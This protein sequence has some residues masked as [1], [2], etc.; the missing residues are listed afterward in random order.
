MTPK[1]SPTCEDVLKENCTKLK[2]IYGTGIKG[3]HSCAGNNQSAIRKAECTAKK[4]NDWCN[5]NF[6]P[7]DGDKPVSDPLAGNW[8]PSPKTKINYPY[9]LQIEMGD[10]NN[11]LTYIQPNDTKVYM[12]KDRY[13]TYDIGNGDHYQISGTLAK[14]V[15]G[16]LIFCNIGPPNTFVVTSSYTR[17]G[18]YNKYD[19]E[20]DYDDNPDIDPDLITYD[21]GRYYFKCPFLPFP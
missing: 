21:E 3:C 14:I 19:S 6:D 4:I 15:D 8:I 13:N 18:K 7:T 1:P 10:T 20:F 12:Y 9:T 17:L 5:D 16:E 2:P 11:Y